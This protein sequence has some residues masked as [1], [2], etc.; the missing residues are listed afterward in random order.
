MVGVVAGAVLDCTVVVIFVVILV[1]V[2]I[3]VVVSRRLTFEYFNL[4][5]MNFSVTKF[6]SIKRF[7]RD[8]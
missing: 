4:L 3:E 2:V 6:I 5:E 8:N 1:V 7:Y